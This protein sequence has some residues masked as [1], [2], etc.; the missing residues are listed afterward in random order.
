M[1]PN[2]PK[3]QFKRSLK[4]AGLLILMMVVMAAVLM[5]YLVYTFKKL[6][7]EQ[8]RPVYLDGTEPS[9]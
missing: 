4:R 5:G 8:T 9:K 1:N 2:D 7:D 6:Q 3:E